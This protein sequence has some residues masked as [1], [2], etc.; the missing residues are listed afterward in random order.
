MNKHLFYNTYRMYRCVYMLQVLFKLQNTIRRC[1]AGHW[2]VR[3]KRNRL[4][5]NSFFFLS[6]RKFSPSK[7]LTQ[8]FCI[9][10]K[11]ITSTLYTY[12]VICIRINAV[13]NSKGIIYLRMHGFHINLSNKPNKMYFIVGTYA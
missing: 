8:Y 3:A 2:V 6:R 1:F 12:V 11:I 4:K 5:K 9:I 10:I 13:R 7:Y